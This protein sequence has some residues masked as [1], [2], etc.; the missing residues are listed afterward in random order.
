MLWLHFCCYGAVFDMP[1]HAL[2]TQRWIVHI[3][4]AAGTFYEGET[5]RLQFTFPDN[6]P[7]EVSASALCVLRADRCSLR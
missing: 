7:I 5:F 2:G 4:G 3:A 6:Y 1:T